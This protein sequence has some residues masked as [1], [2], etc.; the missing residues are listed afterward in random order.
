[1]TSSSKEKTI[2]DQTAEMH[3]NFSVPLSPLLS[4]QFLNAPAELIHLLSRYK[5]AAKMACGKGDILELECG[6]GFGAPILAEFVD[7]YLGIDID[8]KEIESAKHNLNS[9]KF[10]FKN[11][12]LSEH[13][14]FF[15]AIISVN[16]ISPLSKQFISLILNNLKESGIVVLSCNHY[17]SPDLL[18]ENFHHVF[19][20]S[21]NQ[22]ILIPGISNY[23][24]Y[25]LFVSFHRK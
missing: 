22:G 15:D 10:H 24:E 19:S 9:P 12:T 8:S 2:W 14:G 1:M 13:L 23:S 21:M 16:K 6:S 3:G 20:F 5:F 4:A 25:C 17:T 7:T 11:T 18:L